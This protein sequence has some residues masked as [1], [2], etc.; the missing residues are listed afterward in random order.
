MTR[1]SA[2][3]F[4]F[5]KNVDLIASTAYIALSGENGLRGCAF[6]GS[7]GSI[8][9]VLLWSSG[10]EEGPQAV[11][12]RIDGVMRAG[13]T[14]FNRNKHNYILECS[15]EESMKK[16][17]VD[18][19]RVEKEMI[20]GIC[21]SETG[22][23]PAYLDIQKNSEKVIFNKE[24]LFLGSLLVENKDPVEKKALETAL[25]PEMEPALLVIEHKG[26]LW[27]LAVRGFSGGDARGTIEE[28]AVSVS[29]D[30]GLLLNPH[31]QDH[32]ITFLKK[33]RIKNHV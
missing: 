26:T 14:F 28:M 15:W 31:Y 6:G 21:K 2:E 22:G 17:G 7:G 32:E 3:L 30:K 24:D 5:N 29:K 25:A 19:G 23:E 33:F 18:A 27:W 4:V 16:L 11:L 9:I 20:E 12:E 10:P 13:S 1:L 8:T